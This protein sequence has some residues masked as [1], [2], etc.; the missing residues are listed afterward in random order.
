MPDIYGMKK[1][2]LLILLVLFAAQLV[3]AEIESYSNVSALEIY[4]EL[5]TS[6][7]TFETG[8]NPLID[9]LDV[10]LTFIP[11]AD[12]DRQFIVNRDFSSV[13]EAETIENEN[14]IYFFWKDPREKQFSYEVNAKLK[15]INNLNKIRKQ[16]NFPLE[17]LPPEAAPYINPT[18]FIDF[19]QEIREK[20]SEIVGGDT[21]YYQVIHKLAVWVENNIEYDLNTLT[22]EAIQKSSW[23]YKNK[24]GVCDELTNLYISFLR[25]VGIPA[26]F[27]GGQVYSNTEKMFGNHGWAEVFYP[28]VGWMPVDVTFG[29]IG[30]IDATHVKFKESMD[31]GDPSAMYHWKTSDID[32]KRN[33]IS[34]KTYITKAIGETEKHI[35]IMAEPMKKVVGPGSYVPIIVTLTNPN[36]YYVPVLLHMTKAPEAIGSNKRTVLLS[37]LEEKEVYFIVKIPDTAEKNMVYTTIIETRTAFGLIAQTEIK[38]EDGAKKYEK[39]WAESQVRILSPIEEKEFLPDVKLN[40]S[41]EKPYYYETDT[42][43]LQCR[44]KNIGNKAFENMNVCYYRNCRSLGLTIN[45]EKETAFNVPLKG[46]K[47]ERVFVTAE[48]E[49]MVRKAYARIQ[50]I[51][52]PDITILEFRPESVRY[53]DDG[54]FSFLLNSTAPA[55]NIKLVVNGMEY[56]NIDKFD[57]KYEVLAPFESTEFIREKVNVIMTYEDIVGKEYRK[58]LSYVM[59]V[60]EK[61]WYINFM[62]WIEGMFN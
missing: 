45:E 12:G 3:S 9:S 2:H 6:T 50:V 39:E 37:P 51:G 25:S 10:N 52:I 29:Q 48:T 58:D 20:A 21:D 14:Y 55:R 18:E 7:Y 19:N 33:P 13:P 57:T 24:K 62:L 60:T 34:I 31:S 5:S 15:T 28:G 42:A 44:V 53:G 1:W 11:R 22:S 23:V 47:D 30:W 43:K 59:Q 8:M 49:N 40:C 4:T 27:V 17:E 46:F 32:F 26:R 61:P 36:D 54:Q 38:Y 41:F 56:D 16:I 35:G